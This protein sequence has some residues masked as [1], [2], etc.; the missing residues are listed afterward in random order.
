M[1][2]EAVK[3]LIVGT[4]RC[5]SSLLCAILADAGANFAM[6][7]RSEWDR[8]AGAFEH[9]VLQQAGRHVMAMRALE[10][11]KQGSDWAAFKFRMHRSRM[12]KKLRTVLENADFLKCIDLI[13]M[14]H[15]I[16]RLGVDPRIILIYRAPE[17]TVLSQYKAFDWSHEYS[18]RNY[19]NVYRTGLAALHAYGG[20]AIDYDELINAGETAWVKPLARITG[21]T[22]KSLLKAR[23]SRADKIPGQTRMAPLSGPAADTYAALKTCKGVT[24]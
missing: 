11:H 1:A 5:G 12:K 7:A 9:P 23:K 4:G 3:H 19:V 10:E 18:E 14:A 6:S 15:T 17:Q 20:C 21:L 2:E 24:V 22:E 16:G 13:W 8:K